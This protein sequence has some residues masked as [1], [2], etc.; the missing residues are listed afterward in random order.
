MVVL[1]V[2]VLLVVLVTAFGLAVPAVVGRA[3]P[4][5]PASVTP[6]VARTVPSSVSWTGLKAFSF[7]AARARPSG[8]DTAPTL[9]SDSSRW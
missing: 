7:P 8:I 5:H 4:P 6:N 9:D 1:V 3:D 2:L